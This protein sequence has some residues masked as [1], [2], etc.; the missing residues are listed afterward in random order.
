MLWG[1]AMRIFV[2]L[3]LALGIVGLTATAGSA[4]IVI[5][6][7]P[8]IMPAQPAAV[9]PPARPDVPERIRPEGE[10][11]FGK[12]RFAWRIVLTLGTLDANANFVS[13]PDTPIRTVAVL[14]PCPRNGQRWRSPGAMNLNPDW[15]KLCVCQAELQFCVGGVLWLPQLK[16]NWW[17]PVGGQ[18]FGIPNKMIDASLAFCDRCALFNTQ[19]GTQAYQVVK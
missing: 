7:K 14:I 8:D 13:H 17:R 16:L 5:L 6:N 10:V 18:V 4:Q 15:P 9:G 2:T 11:F 12:T 1:D 19:G 3:T